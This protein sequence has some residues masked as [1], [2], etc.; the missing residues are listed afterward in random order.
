M[1]EVRGIS[2]GSASSTTRDVWAPG[3]VV[4]EFKLRFKLEWV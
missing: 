4:L 2:P 1:I 3:G